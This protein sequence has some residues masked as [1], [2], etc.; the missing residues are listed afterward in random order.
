MVIRHTVRHQEAPAIS[1]EVL[2]LQGLHPEADLHLVAVV[3]ALGCH[4]VG[5]HQEEVVQAA[6]SNNYSA[7]TDSNRALFLNQSMK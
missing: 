3:Q 2:I 6:G 4:L 7:L 5:L 1:I